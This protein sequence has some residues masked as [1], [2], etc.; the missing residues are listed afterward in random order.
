VALLALYD[1][2]LRDPQ[3]ATVLGKRTDALVGREWAVQSGAEG[4]AI[5]DD[6]A[7][8]VRAA[9][10]GMAFSQAAGKLSAALLKGVAIAEAMWTVRDGAIV[11]PRRSPPGWSRSASWCATP[12]A[13]RRSPPG[14]WRCIRG[15]RPPNSPRRSA[16]RW[17]SPTLPAGSTC[18]RAGCR[19]AAMPDATPQAF[20]LPFKEAI[21]HLRQ[22]LGRHLPSR[23]WTDTYGRVNAVGFAVAG[24]WKDALLTDLGDAVLKAMQDGTPVAEFQQTFEAI[25][26]RHQWAYKGK[27]AWRA[28]IILNTNLRSAYAAGKWQQIQQVKATRPYLRYVAVLDNRTRRLHREW[29]GRILPVQADWWKTHYPPNGWN[30]RCT[31]MSVSDR[32]LRRHDWKVTANDLDPG[33]VPQKVDPRGSTDAIKAVPAGI[34]PGFEHNPGAV[35]EAPFV[36]QLADDLEQGFVAPIAR[37]AAVDELAKRDTFQPAP[38]AL[39][40]LPPA[41]SVSVN[42]LLPDDISDQDAIDAFLGEFGATADHPAAIDDHAG[43]RLVIGPGM[44]QNRYG[45]TKVDRGMRRPYLLVLADL[46]R[47]PNEVWAALETDAAGRVFVRRRALARF[48]IEGRQMAGLA[49]FEWTSQRSWLGRTIFAPKADHLNADAA[50]Y[51]DARARYGVRLYN[52]IG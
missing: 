10:N 39:P 21:E 11:P 14:C 7:D 38:A 28:A 41:R 50:A 52:R 40:E 8:L 42:R 33:L 4:D 37:K 22:K 47:D 27:P 1:E 34:D 9:I 25:A 31:V 45:I 43:G 44:F 6:A 24:A 12:P 26:A 20:A 2:L 13:W 17:R 32:D 48:E 3:V 23:G 15:C 19:R 36:P 5:A 51:L 16:R 18:R 35:L 46:L 49:A 30:C 29:H